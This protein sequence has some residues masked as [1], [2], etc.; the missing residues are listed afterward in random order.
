MKGMSIRSKLWMLVVFPLICITMLSVLAVLGMS[1]MNQ[2]TSKVNTESVQQIAVLNNISA[3]YAVNVIDAVNKAHVGL[4]R[5]QEALSSATEAQL[6][7]ASAWGRYMN[8]P[9]S[10]E[11]HALAA[12]TQTL[13]DS[14]N[15]TLEVVKEELAQ[16]E[17]LEGAVHRLYGKVDPLSAGLGKLIEFQLKSSDENVGYLEALY[18]RYSSILIVISIIAL[19]SLSLM[20][21]WIF[22]GISEPLTILRLT[23]S[24]LQKEQDLT[25]AVPIIRNDE[26][27]IVAHALND[28]VSYF[29]KLIGEMYEVAEELSTGAEEL[30]NLGLNSLEK[31]SQQRLETDQ[32]V[33]AM[34]EMSA[35]VNEIAQNT[36]HAAISARQAE[37]KAEDG[38]VV[39][40]ETIE[41]MAQLSEQLQ[42]TSKTLQNLANESENINQVMGV[43]RAIAEQT[44]LLALNAAIEAARAG[45][46]GRGFAVVAD[47]VRV[48][49]QRTQN[50]TGEIENTVNRLQHNANQAVES[51]NKGMYEVVRTNELMLTCGKSLGEIVR[52]VNELNSLNTQVA[53]AA[54][55]QSKVTEEIS[56]SIVNISDVA[57]H[58]SD[59]A[60]HVSK[61]CQ[62]LDGMAKLMKSQVSHFKWR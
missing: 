51:M 2:A 59:S 25:V 46:Q 60:N 58:T 39:V 62:N 54:E 30:N 38:Q 8:Q 24:K 1:S 55:E 3:L 33:T 45:E 9:M 12:S 11:E 41:N 4:M 34:N 21:G 15:Q 42:D 52:S 37:N 35:T 16:T 14:V 19:L 56:R 61:K 43:I 57:V 22:K 36:N 29:R 17:S 28:M 44:N 5:R 6:D 40:K 13:I 26:F 49:A 7:A 50:S 10:D 47:E 31:I 27:G 48:L 23:L 53:A 18:S 20:G 32:S